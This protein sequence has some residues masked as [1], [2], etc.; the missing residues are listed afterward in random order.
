MTLTTSSQSS[1]E[2]SSRLLSVRGWSAG[3]SAGGL[4]ASTATDTVLVLFFF[5]PLCF[6][7]GPG[8]VVSAR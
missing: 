6:A 5:A 2:S 4:S 1:A 8:M 7:R 3:G